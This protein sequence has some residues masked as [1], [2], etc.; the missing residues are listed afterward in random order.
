M[1]IPGISNYYIII[2]NIGNYYLGLSIIQIFV[3]LPK[4]EFG[5]PRTLQAS[6]R[7]STSF[8][9]VYGYRV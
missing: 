8:H 4:S 5:T 9:A 3:G 7:E 6:A 2:D 1:V